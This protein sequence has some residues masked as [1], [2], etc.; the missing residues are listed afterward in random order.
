MK[1][2]FE[3][4]AIKFDTVEQRDHLYDLAKEAELELDSC[5]TYNN[6]YFS[7]ADE[8]AFYGDY[9]SPSDLPV[10]HYADFVASLPNSRR[11]S[12]DLISAIESS[13]VNP[14]HNKGDAFIR[15]ATATPTATQPDAVYEFIKSHGLSYELGNAVN[16]ICK[17]NNGKKQALYNAKW[18]IEKA[19]E[20]E[21]KSN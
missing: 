9:D 5:R 3:G 12:S 7:E 8:G 19:I 4:I 2:K 1:E 10:I 18:Y 21:T 17:A 14:Q 16:F 20:H 6:G 13:M 11:I 15:T